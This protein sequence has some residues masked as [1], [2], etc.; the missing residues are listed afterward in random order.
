MVDN[1]NLSTA[2]NSDSLSIGIKASETV[3]TSKLEESISSVQSQL[4]SDS[5]GNNS[6]SRNSNS[7]FEE[8]NNV[9]QRRST[10]NQNRVSRSNSTAVRANA[11]TTVRSNNIM[12]RQT[13]RQE[14]R[15]ARNGVDIDVVANNR[16]LDFNNKATN[17]VNRHLDVKDF[18]SQRQNR[19][20][21]TFLNPE[22]FQ[23]I[24]KYLTGS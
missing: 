10:E 21:Q 2:A 14:S 1:V 8:S 20:K 9:F 5:Q 15:D 6:V 23:R 17:I 16:F 24:T 4:T 13:A 3:D 18:N 7:I 12:A 19:F 11:D 22:I